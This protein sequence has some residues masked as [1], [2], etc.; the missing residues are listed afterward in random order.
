MLSVED[1]PEL[2]G[3]KLDKGGMGEGRVAA[4]WGNKASPLV[5]STR[6]VCN[7]DSSLV[8]PGTADAC[9]SCNHVT[10]RSALNLV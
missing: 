4:S 8:A 2:V 9:T 1:N 6:S 3:E 10:A 5:A 7:L